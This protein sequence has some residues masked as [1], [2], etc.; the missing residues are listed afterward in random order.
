MKRFGVKARI[1][2]LALVF[3]FC[4]LAVYYTLERVQVTIPTSAGVRDDFFIVLDA[5]HGGMD[6][7][8][9]TAD[10]VT[11]KGINLNILLSVRDLCRV[12]GYNVEVTRDTDTSIHDKGVEGVGNQKRSDMDNRL[13]LFNKHS[14]ALCISIH[15]NKFTETSSHGAQM[16]Y[17]D[18]NPKNEGIARLMQ[19]KFVEY[20]QPDNTREVKLCGKELFL[21]AFCNNP[22]VMI[23]CGFLSNP[24][25]AVKL[26][27][28]D[29]QKQIA[30]TIF[31]GINSY[32]QQ[33][34]DAVPESTISETTALT[35][36]SAE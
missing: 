7:G 34:A 24:E 16:F 25:E 36:V 6:G 22:T 30:F 27:A 32:V 15:Q 33:N 11:E 14:N 35:T 31:S 29:Y 9:S 20:L 21:C 13:A 19:S 5:G 1:A 8:C 2:T 12:L 23:E 18:N 3:V 17:S 26:Q 4:Y 10:G 28:E